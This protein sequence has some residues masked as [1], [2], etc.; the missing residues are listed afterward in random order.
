MSSF[1][2]N[3]MTTL[4]PF[5]WE[6]GAGRVV[7]ADSAARGGEFLCLECDGA[8][9]LR[10]G[11]VRVAH[12]AHH[13]SGH[14]DCGGGTPE[15]W[16][17]LQAKEFIRDFLPN[18]R[19]IA[20]CAECGKE[21]A[22]HAFTDCVVRLEEKCDRYRPDAVIWRGT[23]RVATVEVWHTHRVGEEKAAFFAA[24]S[25]LMMEMVAT[26]VIRE[27]RDGTY[28]ARYI[29]SRCADCLYRATHTRCAVCQRWELNERV[30]H[31][32]CP[33][34]K[35]LSLCGRC[36]KQVPTEVLRDARCPACRR[37]PCLA[38]GEW[39]PLETLVTTPPPRDHGFPMAFLHP[40]C[41]VTCAHC[42]QQIPRSDKRFCGAC[43]MRVCQWRAECDA[44]LRA[45]KRAELRHLLETRPPSEPSNQLEAALAS[46]LEQE[47]A[48]RLQRWRNDVGAALRK[49]KSETLRALIAT[50]PTT[51]SVDTL[52]QALTGALEAEEADRAMVA[53]W[54]ARGLADEAARLAR[55]ADQQPRLVACKRMALGLTPRAQQK[56]Y[57]TTRYKDGSERTDVKRRLFDPSQK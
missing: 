10:R 50:R 52:E 35:H 21:E 56:G 44:A 51:E 2:I 47:E 33:R 9:T 28:R 36:K 37:R 39:A 57:L 34:C 22:P 8:L 32:R 42:P 30:A 1:L 14:T 24:R 11:S 43:D 19:F 3:A 53:S 55:E 48:E 16:Q 45:P 23:E 40:A 5:A 7:E 27:H 46:I 13:R 6:R 38:C 31:D 49:P 17:H 41:A 26:S 25:L 29:G 54:R 4:N 15:S 12:F 20:S 18:W